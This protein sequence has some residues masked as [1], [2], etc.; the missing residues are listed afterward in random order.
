MSEKIEKALILSELGRFEAARELLAEVLAA[1]PDNA[2]ALARMAD[3]CRQLG[4]Y[5]RALEFSAAALR[6]APNADYAWRIRALSEYRLNLATKGAPAA[7]HRSRALAAARRAV[8]LSPDE[9][10]SLRVQAIVQWDTDPTAAL[11]VLDRALELDPDNV[12]SH[13]L[14]GLIFRWQLRAP[15]ALD[16]AEAAFRE[17]LRL[18]PEHSQALYEL[19]LITVERGDIRRARQQL[20]RVAELDPGYGDNVREQL[21]RVTKL[22]NSLAAQRTAREAAAFKGNQLTSGFRGGRFGRFAAFFVVIM[23]I[24]GLVS[25]CSNDSPS[26]AHDN[27]YPTQPYL[28]SEYLHPPTFPPRPTLPPDWRSQ[29]PQ[30]TVQAPGQP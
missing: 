6:V 12:R 21:E 7:E 3:L 14:R 30:P 11:R 18:Q 20:R 15:D 1:E 8:E 19:A 2:T 13:V 24:R 28:P 23:L 5:E 17:A 29:F 25:A 4:E 27:R 16:R 9:V 10:E 22:A 26:P